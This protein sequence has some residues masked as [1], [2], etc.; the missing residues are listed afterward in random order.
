MKKVLAMVICAVMTV[1]IIGCSSKND[2]P[3]K[4]EQNNNVESNDASNGGSNENSERIMYFGKVKSIVGNEIELELAENQDGNNEEDDKQAQI[5]GQLGAGL[6]ATDT[7]PNDALFD[8]NEGDGNSGGNG[9]G[10]NAELPES[11][12]PKLELKYTGETKTFTISAG[13]TILDSRTVSES[14]LSAIKKGTVIRI[15]ATGT[16]ESPVVSNVEI[17]E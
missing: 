14:K 3:P 2:N 5:S 9:G 8:P 15:Y 6:S 11:N 13:A 12:T 16:K 17:V 4:A 7:A 1:T 10:G